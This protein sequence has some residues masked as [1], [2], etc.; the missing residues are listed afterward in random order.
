[1]SDPEAHISLRD[2]LLRKSIHVAALWIPAGYIL[3]PEKMI[4]LPLTG[5]VTIALLVE[6][7]R[8]AYPAF[9]EWFEGFLGSLLRP[10]E[11][12]NVTGATTMLISALLAVIFFEQWIAI[13]AMLLMLVSDAVGALVGRFFGK[14]VYRPGR[15]VE[16]SA[17]FVVSGFLMI[18]LVP[19]ARLGIC[20]AG[21]IAGLIFEVGILKLD[22]NIAVPLGA[23]I[24]MEILQLI[25]PV[26]S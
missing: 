18:P 24:V 22:D 25:F 1:M 6:I 10:R 20:F 12:K 9:E 8:T 5:V 23:G 2:E 7:F 15:T 3:L 19:D 21:V 16:G 26:V 11:R 17:A 4:L 13:L 14:W